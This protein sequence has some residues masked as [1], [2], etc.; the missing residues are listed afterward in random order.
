MERRSGRRAE[1]GWVKRTCADERVLPCQTRLLTPFLSV[2]TLLGVSTGGK[3][4]DQK[5][6]EEGIFLR[7]VGTQG[8]E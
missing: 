1:E 6:A 7:V 5:E 2:R 8:S 3:W 4:Q